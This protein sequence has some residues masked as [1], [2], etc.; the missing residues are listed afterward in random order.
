M[1]SHCKVH[2]D[3]LTL[4][5]FPA[6]KNSVASSNPS[7]LDL[8]FLSLISFI[9]NSG[10]ILDLRQH[11]STL[12]SKIEKRLVIILNNKFSL[13]SSVYLARKVD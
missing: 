9:P 4:G 11:Q 5:L 7:Q 6:H 13:E 1:G 3:L 8:I 2:F 12:G 10:I